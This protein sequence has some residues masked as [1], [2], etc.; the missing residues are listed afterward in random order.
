MVRLK[1]F[2]PTTLVSRDRRVTTRRSW[3]GV[4]CATERTRSLSSYRVEAWACAA[5]FEERA[6]PG[7]K[8]ESLRCDRARKLERSVVARCSTLEKSADRCETGV[9]ACFQP[10]NST[11]SVETAWKFDDALNK[12]RLRSR[13]NRS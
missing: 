1:K 4:A 11:T 10:V 3:A 12:R 6:L 7:Q 9:S 2:S 13:Q 5:C 8:F